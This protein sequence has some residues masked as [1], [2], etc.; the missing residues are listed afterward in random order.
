M[1]DAEAVARALDAADPLTRH[2]DRFLLPDGPDGPSGPPAA[3]FAGQS[4]GLQSVGV[5]DAIEAQLDAW[6]HLGIEG[7]FTAPY[8]WFTLDDTM[9]DA[10]G[11]IV[12]ARSDEVAILN[13]LTVN[14]QLLLASFFRPTGTRRR[15]LVDGPLFPSDRHALTSHLAWH[16]LDPATDLVT[17]DPR[18]DEDCVRIEDLEAAIRDHGPSLALV[19]LAGVNFATGQA[20]PIGRLTA[21]AHEV[22]AIA[23]W[24]LAHSAG[25]MPLALHDDDVD[26]ATWC[27]YKYLNS[28]PGGPGAIFV[29]ERQ[30]ARDDIPRLTGWWGARP[31][32]RFDPD[33]P[34]VAGP[35]A[36]AWKAS[37]NPVLAMTP[38][39]VSLAIF[40]EVGMPVL[41]ERSVRLTGDLERRLADLGVEVVTPTAP[42]RRGSQL[43]MRFADAPAVLEAMG[44]RGIVAD[45][46][47]PDIIRVAPIPLYNT[48][49]DAWRLEA[50]LADV[51]TTSR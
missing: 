21:A 15:I 27:T 34:F 31:D 35:G 2:R 5:R 38:L 39:A 23:G 7:M 24:D 43:S 13:T 11:R 28:G 51:M 12:G 40:D 47:S 16:G 19:F 17:I 41:R 8:D 4:L 37:T 36:S 6:A 46:R 10:M 25:N 3:Y 44:A 33:G 22:G 49:H 48:F 14:I 9:R 29:H 20:L 18:A 30:S 42:D 26:F 50:A 45:F 1:T 32:H